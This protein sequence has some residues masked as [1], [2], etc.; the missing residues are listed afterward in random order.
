MS[1]QD[2]YVVTVGSTGERRQPYNGHVRW[3]D[4]AM[5]PNWFASRKDA[6][7]AAAELRRTYPWLKAR[8]SR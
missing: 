2:G 3:P 7:R 5:G 4:G 6:T 1:K 8:V